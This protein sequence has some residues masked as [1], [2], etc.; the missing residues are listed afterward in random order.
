MARR[1]VITGGPGTG[2]TALVRELE[3][4][5]YV[6]FHEIIREMTLEAKK[7]RDGTEPLIN[8]LAFVSDPYA[9]NRK[10][11]HGRMQQYQHAS[12]LQEPFVFYDRGIPDVI[13]YMDYFGQ[14]YCEEFTGPCQDL[15]YDAAILLP[16][17]EEIYT[18]DE[19]RLESFQQACEIH[20]YL[21]RSYAR[22]GYRV[23]TLPSGSVK[24]RA[25]NLLGMIQQWYG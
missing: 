5:G 15:R 14:G 23:Q 6:C 25:E 3:G 22:C 24:D 13:A 12:Q 16:P 1:I 17:W 10:I 4:R 21:A 7:G 8:P 11:L 2:K 9:F 20:D 18:R 19:A